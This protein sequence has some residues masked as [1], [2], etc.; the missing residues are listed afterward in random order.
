MYND[1]NDRKMELERLI[2]QKNGQR[3]KQ[4]RDPHAEAVES[5][6][7]YCVKGSSQKRDEPQEIENRVFRMVEEMPEDLK[8][9]FDDFEIASF[10]INRARK[11][12]FEFYRLV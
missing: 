5:F 12:V 1:L 2:Y 7:R 6:V 10:I 3:R 11:E 4:F 8:G 9:E